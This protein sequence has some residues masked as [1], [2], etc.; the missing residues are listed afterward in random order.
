MGGGV[1]WGGRVVR[2]EWLNK[3]QLDMSKTTEHEPQKHSNVTP[4]R[5]FLP[6]ARLPLLLPASLPPCTS[7]CLLA[8]QSACRTSCSYSGHQSAM[9]ALKP[10]PRA[11]GSKEREGDRQLE[12][13]RHQHLHRRQGASQR[14]RSP[15]TSP[16]PFSPPLSAAG[17]GRVL[18][19]NVRKVLK[20]HIEKHLHGTEPHGIALRGGEEGKQATNA[21]PVTQVGVCHKKN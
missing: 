18:C 1:G 7:A 9:H 15:L 11:H 5:T 19:S 3:N 14:G 12:E 8:I 16:L 2:K 20:E 10:L 13:R 4:A 6:P 17:R 21:Q